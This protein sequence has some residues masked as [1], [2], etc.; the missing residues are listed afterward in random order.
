MT[1]LAAF[2]LPLW[3]GLAVVGT[4]GG[5][6]R[7][8]S[9][10]GRLLGVVLALPL[11]L[12]LASALAFL[13]LVALR[14]V[15]GAGGEIAL[16]ALLATAA[17][18]AWWLRRRW[19]GGALAPATAAPRPGPLLAGLGALALAVGLGRLVRAWLAVTARRPFSGGDAVAIWN[20]KARFLV[21]PEGWERAFSPEIAWSHPDYPLLLPAFLARTWAWLGDPSWVAPAATGLA[22]LVLP[23]AIAAVAAHRWRGWIPALVSGV[24]VCGVARLSLGFAQYADMPLATYFL[25]CNVLLVEHARRPESRGTLLLAGLAAGAMVWTKNEGWAMLLALIASAA[26]ATRGA[27][28]PWREARTRSLAFAAGLLPLAG[29]TVLFKLI[30]APP[31]DLAA[32]VAW[33]GL[34]DTGRPGAIL[35]RVASSLLSYGPFHLPLAVVLLALLLVLGVAVPPALRA[36]TAS[37]AIRLSL[38]LAA[39]CTAFAVTPYPLEWHLAT[40]LERLLSQLFPSAVLL[41]TVAMGP[42]EDRATAPGGAP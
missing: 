15:V 38:V 16:E 35:G 20:L 18:A 28:L 30:L 36:A 41:A 32:G 31:N 8:G 14:P 2:L 6:G 5:F 37:L 10:S 19:P 42:V 3:L 17:T 9:A 12:A 1:L 40:S 27:R 33:R 25:A 26:V 7:D 11:G 29:T 34:A 4:C 21:S 23:V 13:W 24:L 39:Y 22:F